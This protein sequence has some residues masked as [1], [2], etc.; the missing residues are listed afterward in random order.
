MKR[1]LIAL[2]G[3][4]LVTVGVSARVQTVWA[5]MDGE[6]VHR[7]L[8]NFHTVQI[9]GWVV[10][11]GLKPQAGAYLLTS[12]PSGTWEGGWPNAEI[13]RLARPDVCTAFHNDG[14]ACDDESMQWCGNPKLQIPDGWRQDCVGI[15][16]TAVV[17]NYNPGAYRVRFAGSNGWT[18]EVVWSPLAHWFYQP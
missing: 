16:A 9:V 11:N 13:V 6:V 10:G 18:G 17:T 1:F 12:T 8:G 3:A 15:Q 2:L 5:Y 7:Y 4:L 14:K